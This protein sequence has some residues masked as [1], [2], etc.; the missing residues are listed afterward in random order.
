LSIRILPPLRF[1]TVLVL[2]AATV[3]GGI[4]TLTVALL[5]LYFFPKL[6]QADDL[7]AV[8]EATES[9]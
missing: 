2:T 4:C 5:W 7:S 9:A 1:S 3:L 6:R 8:E